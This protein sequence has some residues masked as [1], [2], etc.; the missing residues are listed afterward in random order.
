MTGIKRRVCGA[1]LSA[2][3]I[4]S[5]AP[6]ALA[7]ETAEATTMRMTKTEGTVKI[8][9]SS[10]RN[11]SVIK[12]LLLRSGYRVK[13]EEASYAWISLDSAKLVKEDAASDI[14]I[15]KSG[16][17]LEVLINEGNV[18]FNVTEPL[19][20]D[21]SLNIRTSTLVAGIRG[22]SGWVEALDQE[23]SRIGVLE[24]TVEIAVSDPVTGEAENVTVGSGE[25]AVCAIDPEGGVAE[26][27]RG[28]ITAEN[29]SGFVLTEA[30]SD[31]ELCEKI[32]DASGLDLQNS[33]VDPA[34]R[35]R[36]DQA[37]VREQMQE[38][39]E[40][41]S[42]QE[43]SVSAP[44]VGGA[45]AADDD[46]DDDDDDYTPAPQ[47]SRPANPGG[48]SGTGTGGSV[49]RPEAGYTITFDANGGTVNPGTAV[50][51]RDGILVNWPKAVRDGYVFDGWYTAPTLTGGS[52]VTA[53]TAF[54]MDATLYAHWTKVYTVTLDAN[55][56]SF[57]H[58]F[59]L[60][61]SAGTTDVKTGT[62]G[63]LNWVSL[64]APKPGTA[65]SGLVFD[66]WYDQPGAGGTKITE[67]TVFTKDT[68][69]YAHWLQT[70][71][72]TFDAGT[73]GSV[74]P[75]S[76]AT[77]AGGKLASLPMPA[78]GASQTDKVFIGWFDQ[79]TGGTE[80]T[81]D[82]E[83]TKDTTIYARWARIA[84]RYDA[85][86][87]TLTIKGQ[88]PME[89]IEDYNTAIPWDTYKSDI[90]KAVIENGVSTIGKEA[91]YQCYNLESVEIPDSVTKIDESA[92]YH[93]GSLKNITIPNSV[94]SIGKA[95]FQNCSNL[96]SVAIPAGITTIGDNTFRECTGLSSVTI[97]SS[98]TT[99]GDSAFYHCSSLPSVTIP[100]NVTMNNSAFSGCGL[101]SVTIPSGVSKIDD[102]VFANCVKLASVTIPSG[103]TSIG[104]SA[105]HSCKA[106]TS[107]TI[108][109]GVT[110]IGDYAFNGCA[111]LTSV[112]IRPDATSSTASIGKWSFENCT[113]LAT[114]TISKNV[115][116]IGQQAFS[117]CTALATVNY[118]GSAA[119]WSG[120]TIDSAG[121]SGNN[122]P[123]TNATRNDNYTYTYSY[124]PASIVASL[125]AFDAAPVYT[126]VPASAWYAEAAAYCRE[127]GLMVG[128]SGSVFSPDSHMTRAMMVTVLHRLAGKPAAPATASFPD[129]GKDAW[130]AGALSWASG[131][132]IIK[133]YSDGSFGPNNPVTH[134]QVALIFQRYSGDPNVQT[135]GADTPDTLATR[136]EVAATLM[137]FAGTRA[138]AELSSLS[139]MDV[140]CAPSGIAAD[141]D[142]SLL[143]TDVYNKQIW[144]VRDRG[145]KVYAG[146]ATTE[147]LYGQPVGGYH[148]AGLRDSYFREPWAVAPYLG[149]WAVSDAGNN[150][151]RLIQDNSVRTLRAATKEKLKTTKSGVA[152]DHPTGLA[153]DD[154]GNLYV[155]DTF[156]GA[157]RKITPGG[158]ASTVA[159]GL[160]DP[161]GLCW[162][163]GVLYIAETGGNRIMKVEDGALSCLAGSGQE[164]LSNGAAERAAFSAP[165][166][167]AV[168]SDGSVYVA[169][170]NNSAVRKIRNGAVTTL[171]VRNM[172]QVDGGLTSPVGL[173]VQD[174][175]L[176]ICDTFTKK[177]FVCRL[178]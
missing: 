95:A 7:A 169:D 97:P 167:V 48:S 100:D 24:G 60:L 58:L 171:A 69:L 90:K 163:D 160:S 117:G 111:G 44:S 101:T 168:D 104:E 162:K 96:K 56:G 108:P 91:F 126:D 66:G 63:K 140:I 139:A 125:V 51:A 161:M 102:N 135:I 137:D 59:P 133:G 13:T 76:A 112:E 43:N 21:E 39:E 82:T 141:G 5:C 74:N 134:R 75:A 9:N 150:V 71:T 26:V 28:E 22:T 175:R 80:V 155:S 147:D 158:E 99:I 61:P 149:G 72:V 105:F 166:G 119:D 6:T 23:T 145:S 114:V 156:N 46:D 177:V 8:T 34:E 18:F 143:V 129:V 116:T 4:L 29:I 138:P 84:A 50:T 92:F 37:S 64:P 38:I 73:G 27:E 36:Q 62:D 65:Q 107:V 31:P 42:R 152:F 25:S 87:R 124:T 115:K 67:D 131:E 41:V 174:G 127:Q 54:R 110:S 53:N 19:E 173:L 88:G 89:D 103:V 3:L 35:L 164:G 121:I 120:I 159:S 32:A 142:G 78:P 136:A 128:T 86:T 17:K 109:G 30:V 85:N 154:Q 14:E 157:V 68:T 172:E 144:R 170:T 77:G 1:L 81:E 16:K 178:G 123:L 94:T 15:R 93:C 146:G 47:P 20:D 130:Y 83:F 165:Q 12:N 132:N 55:G 79:A 40:Q 45:S 49:A 11:V 113:S 118:E 57:A 33:S 148:D 10:G 70:Y 176:Y 151:I 106:L 153:A 52:L 98:V 2:A 122:A